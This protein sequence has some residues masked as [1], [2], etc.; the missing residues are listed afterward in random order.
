LFN[1]IREKRGLAY[2]IGTHVKFMADTG[3]FI[4]HAGVDNTKVEDTVELIFDGLRLVKDR[5]V[6]IDELKR[7]KEYY[8]GQLTLAMEDT[9]D[10][11]LWIGETTTTL[12]K[13]FA[14]ED[15]IKEVKKVSPGDIRQ[16]SR[17]II[18][19]ENINFAMIGPWKNKEHAVRTWLTL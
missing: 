9:M 3:A 18:K 13:T 11:M 2:E 17:D 12:D 14:L 8:L 5:L 19:P 7:A 4:V 10:Q 1:E 15:I 16:I 6:P